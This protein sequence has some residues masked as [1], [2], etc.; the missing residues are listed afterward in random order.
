MIIVLTKKSDY[1]L[2]LPQKN[3]LRDDINII[4]TL[5]GTKAHHSTFKVRKV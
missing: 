3:F 5:T 2:T 4:E 1:F